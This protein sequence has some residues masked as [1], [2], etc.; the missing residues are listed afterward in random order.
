[1]PYVSPHAWVSAGGQQV[2]LTVSTPAKYV[3]DERSKLIQAVPANAL[4][5]GAPQE[6]A[7]TNLL[8]YSR[9]LTHADWTVVTNVTIAAD[10]VA[11]PDGVTSAERVTDNDTDG[12]HRIYREHTFATNAAHTFSVCVKKGTLDYFG[13]L[14]YDGTDTFWASFNLLT[15]ATGTTGAG[16]MAGISTRENGW[17]RCWITATCAAAAGNVQLVCKDAATEA[18]AANSYIGSGQTIYWDMAQLEVGAYPTSFI[19]TTTATVSRAADA[20]RLVNAGLFGPLANEGSLLWVGR[21]P[22][23]A[24]S[25]ATTY[26]VYLNSSNA[27]NES[28]GFVV[29]SSRV[30]AGARSNNVLQFFLTANTLGAFAAGTHCAALVTWRNANARL[31]VNGVLEATDTVVTPPQSLDRLELGGITSGSTRG[32]YENF[33]I[34]CFDRALQDHEAQAL[35]ANPEALR[36]AS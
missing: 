4:G 13:L 12:L 3:Y 27:A 11:G 26:P 9:D 2:P 20:V 16:T 33:L 30:N 29:D 10:N 7:R 17:Y 28:V 24:A 15:Y 32:G 5:W 22:M 21:F 19:P 23:A 8:T 18:S 35:T 25:T 14:M 1:M 34:A 36:W 31:F 6:P